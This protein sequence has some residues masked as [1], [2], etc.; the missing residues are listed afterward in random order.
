MLSDKASST[1]AGVALLKAIDNSGNDII[2]MFVDYVIE[3]TTSG[4]FR[5]GTLRST[6][7]GGLTTYDETSTG[8]I[9]GTTNGLRLL[10]DISGTDFRLLADN[11]DASS[12]NVTFSIKL[13]TK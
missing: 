3:N 6:H 10:T 7:A 8:D 5:A 13:I 9:G 4:G 1:S 2:G 12:Y 11:A